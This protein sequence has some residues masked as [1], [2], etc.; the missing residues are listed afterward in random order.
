[1][2]YDIPLSILA[3]HEVNRTCV[4]GRATRIDYVMGGQPNFEGWELRCEATA[5][6]RGRLARGQHLRLRF[7]LAGQPALQLLSDQDS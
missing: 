5:G 4:C 2:N 1:M 6:I 7:H 3:A